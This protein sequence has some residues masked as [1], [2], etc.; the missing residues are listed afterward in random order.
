MLHAYQ[1]AWLPDSLLA[2]KR[3]GELVAALLRA[4][5]IWTVSLHTNKGLGGGAPEAIAGA[6]ETTMNPQVLSAFAL[7]ICAAEDRPARDWK[8]AYWGEHYP[9]LARAKRKYDPRWIFSGR[10]CVEPA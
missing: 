1:S 9:V 6:R 2:E 3:R 5:K 10:N 7:L 4:S 8:R